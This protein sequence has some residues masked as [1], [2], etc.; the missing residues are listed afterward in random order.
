MITPTPRN[1]P[2]TLAAVEESIRKIAELQRQLQQLEL[3]LIEEISPIN[4]YY[5]KK[6][7][8]LQ[9]KIGAL[10]SGLEAWAQD[11]KTNLINDKT[12]AVKLATGEIGWRISAPSVRF[13]GD[14]LIEKLKQ[15]GLANLIRLKEEVSKEAIL[16]NPKTIEGIDGIT[17]V[18]SET[19]WI[20]PAGGNELKTKYE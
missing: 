11:N 6:A 16:A 17:I 19:F 14:N 3:S 9:D 2:Q 8:P 1:T 10:Q 18:R 15:R 13:T 20:K 7:K 5:K 12:R 4:D